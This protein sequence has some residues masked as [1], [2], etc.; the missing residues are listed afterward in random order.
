MFN[1]GDYLNRYRVLANKYSA[2]KQVIGEILGEFGFNFKPSQLQVKNNI[3]RIETK[4]II[5]GELL[6]KKT[7]ILNRFKEC[8]GGQII[9][10]K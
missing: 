1:L 5:K 10:L 6:I 7:D 2:D 3:L 8:L 4:P 9:D